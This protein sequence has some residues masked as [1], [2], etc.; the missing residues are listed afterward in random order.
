MTNI[1]ALRNLEPLAV[2]KRIARGLLDVKKQLAKQGVPQR[3][4]NNTLL[5][6]S[7]NLR[8]FDSN[9]FGHGRRLAES[10]F[11]IAETISAFDFVALQEINEDL[12]GFKKLMRRLGP[13]WKYIA[14]DTSGNNERMVFVFDRRKCWFRDIAGEIV[15]PFK[16]EFLSKEEI[17]DLHH[18]V[19]DLNKK[20]FK[21]FISARNQLN[22]NRQFNRTP[23][24]VAMQSGWFK[25]KICTVHIYY[26]KDHGEKLKRRVREI[27]ET[28]KFL[29]KR[30]DKE[31]NEHYILLGDFNIMSPEHETMKALTEAGFRVPE[32]LDTTNIKET[33]YYDQIA[34]RLKKKSL[35]PKTANVFKINKAVYRNNQIETYKPFMKKISKK[36]KTLT[37]AELDKYYD[38]WRTFQISDHNLLW[39]ELQINFSDDYLKDRTKDS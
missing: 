9:K 15:L 36:A 17:G 29:R 4:V 37:N 13:N 20:D 18:S 7:W 14:T 11:Y 21:K 31:P 24:M 19:K 5:L 28:A 35:L 34:F 8:D 33:K 12:T 30:S 39:V 3:N 2:R 6:A 1:G 32:E 27:R 38:E 22:P 25:F 23:F 26:G 10:I 16:N